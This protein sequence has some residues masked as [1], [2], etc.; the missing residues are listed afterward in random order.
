[1]QLPYHNIK[2]F[3]LRE[4]FIKDACPT[5]DLVTCPEGQ[6]CEMVDGLPSCQERVPGGC[7]TNRCG[8]GES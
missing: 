5:C 6:Q 7:D 1:M 8:S 3:L 2:Y 4:E